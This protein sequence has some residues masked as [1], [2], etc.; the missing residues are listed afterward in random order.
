[1]EAAALIRVALVAALTYLGI[2]V[3]TNAFLFH[4]PV[5]WK[6]LDPQAERLRIARFA[7]PIERLRSQGGDD[8]AQRA[9]TLGIVFLWPLFVVPLLRWMTELDR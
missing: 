4:L 5:F 8:L 7:P 9:V 3:A 2:G 1:V 6:K